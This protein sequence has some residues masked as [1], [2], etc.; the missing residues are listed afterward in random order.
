MRLPALARRHPADHFGAIGEGLLRV[1][2]ALRAG[3]ALA[4][5]FGVGVDE[6][7]HQL[8]RLEWIDYGDG[9]VFLAVI[10]VF[11]IKHWRAEALGGSD[12]RAVEITDLV[13]P[14]EL[15]A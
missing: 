11:G 8:M 14:R 2:C 4:D 12:N 1:K 6:D 3:E 7:G 10:E 9:A 13:A 15:D 5:D